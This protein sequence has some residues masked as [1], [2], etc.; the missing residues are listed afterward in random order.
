M[1]MG[2]LGTISEIT[3]YM[4]LSGYGC[5]SEPKLAQLGVT[6]VVAATNMPRSRGW[7]DSIQHVKVGA[8]VRARRTRAGD[9]P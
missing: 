7:G 2:L 9:S 6:C 4:Y 3:P 1:S 8:C 5:L